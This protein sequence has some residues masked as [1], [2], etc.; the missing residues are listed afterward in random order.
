[1]ATVKKNDFEVLYQGSV[2]EYEGENQYIFYNYDDEFY[3]RYNVEDNQFTEKS[4]TN[5]SETQLNKIE[6]KILERY[7]EDQREHINTGIHYQNDYETY[8]G[9]S[10]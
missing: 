7:S 5:L 6:A 1:M 10:L 9:Y 2:V 4:N 3:F 8:G